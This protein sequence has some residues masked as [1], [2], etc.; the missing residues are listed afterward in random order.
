MR[1]TSVLQP[2]NPPRRTARLERSAPLQPG[3]AWSRSVPPLAEARSAATR[4]GGSASGKLVPPPPGEF[5]AAV[6]LLIRKRAGRGDVF[7]AYCESCGAW[8]GEKGG[9]F[10]HRDARGMGG[11][12]DPVVNGPTGGT[13]ACGSGT[14]RTGCHGACEDRDEH[15]NAMGFWL[16]NGQNPRTEPIMLHGKGSGGITVWLAADGLGP[17]GTGYLYEQPG[18][19]AA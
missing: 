6:R 14:L 17:D 10:S 7:E 3:G 4:K 12:R 18:E 16:R 13:L 2:G 9:E 15:M 8:L 5:T 19:M 1:R 11:S